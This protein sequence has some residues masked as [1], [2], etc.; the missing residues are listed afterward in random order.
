VAGRPVEPPVAVAD[1]VRGWLAI[2]DHHDDAL[3]AWV[4]VQ[5]APGQHQP[6]LQVGAL[7]VAHL[8]GGQVDGGTTSAT[9]AKA[10]TCRASRG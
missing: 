6:V 2:G 1:Q 3:G 4:P 7:D 9:L 10:M 8:Q 5:E